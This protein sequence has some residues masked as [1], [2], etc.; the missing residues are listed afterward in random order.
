MNAE[1]II[2]AHGDHE[3]IEPMVEL[4]QE[5]GY[6]KDKNVHLMSNGAELVV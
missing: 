3:K 4:C 1:H 2:P 5:L 6:K